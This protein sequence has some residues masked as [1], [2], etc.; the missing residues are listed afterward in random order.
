MTRRTYAKPTLV[1]R[2]LLPVTTG[3]TVIPA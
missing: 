2:D 3:G 1:K